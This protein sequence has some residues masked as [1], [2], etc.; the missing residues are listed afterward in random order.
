MNQRPL[1]DAGKPD[2]AART[3]DKVELMMISSPNTRRKSISGDD[4]GR[5]VVH[6]SEEMI[7]VDLDKRQKALLP[8]GLR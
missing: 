4:Q 7:Y 3:A 6:Y 1:P 2:G 8:D 5:S